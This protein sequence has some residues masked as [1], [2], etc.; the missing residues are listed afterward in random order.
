LCGIVH[1]EETFASRDYGKAPPNRARATG[2]KMVSRRPSAEE[3]S[4]FIGLARICAV[5]F[6]LGDW[7]LEYCPGFPQV[8]RRA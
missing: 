8:C 7:Y 1:G 4:K 3:C 6:G 5:I 2:G